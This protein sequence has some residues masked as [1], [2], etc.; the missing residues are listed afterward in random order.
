MQTQTK[1]ETAT[2]LAVILT[3]HHNYAVRFWWSSEIGDPSIYDTSTTLNPKSTTMILAA[4]GS[5]IK[6]SK[7]G[8]WVYKTLGMVT[9]QYQMFE[10]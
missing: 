9:H 8:E 1:I 2:G 4:K 5:C 6:Q 7:P 3:N 10:C